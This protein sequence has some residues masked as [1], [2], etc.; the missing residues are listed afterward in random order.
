MLMW[1]LHYNM[2]LAELNIASF[3]GWGSFVLFLFVLCFTGFCCLKK[4][5]SKNILKYYFLPNTFT[6]KAP[7]NHSSQKKYIQLF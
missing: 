2:Y 1:L 4:G 3:Y 5:I 7:V 6:L